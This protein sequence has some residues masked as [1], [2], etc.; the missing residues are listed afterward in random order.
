MCIQTNSF[1]PI[2]TK[3][4]GSVKGQER[5][6]L[7]LRRMGQRSR[8]QGQSLGPMLVQRECLFWPYRGTGRYIH[9]VTVKHKYSLI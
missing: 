2:Y 9:M 7:I 5:T 1:D 8:S 6:D 4:G 3:L